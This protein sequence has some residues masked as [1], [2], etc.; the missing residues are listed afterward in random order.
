[1]ELKHLRLI[2]TIADQGN[3]ANARDKLFLTTSA[4]SHQLRS[5]EMELGFKIFKRERVEWRLTEPG[6]ELYVLATNVLS[7][8]DEKLQQIKNNN[9]NPGGKIR[10]SSECYTFYLL[11]PSFLERM[12]ALYPQIDIQLLY[13]TTH[14]PLENLL[15]YEVDV[16]VVTTR[17]AQEHLNTTLILKD[18]LKAVI[19]RENPLAT[20]KYLEAKHFA[21]E[22]LIIHSYPIETVTIYEK[23]LKPN[24]ISPFR[25][26]AI[27]LTEL[28]LEMVRTN[29]GITCMPEWML[30]PFSYQKDL[31]FKQIGKNRLKRNLYIVMRNEDL[32]KRHF[33]DFKSNFEETI[34]NDFAYALQ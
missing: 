21:N 6:T 1:M 31:V 33:V 18:E 13:N 3:I 22:H 27:P 5:L 2:K 30:K 28:S 29:R 24:N 34:R 7:S 8:V 20:H 4:I 19:H 17:P 25:I 9:E 23:Y 10:V 14:H 16:A 15:N 32:S 12:S 11:F 26:S